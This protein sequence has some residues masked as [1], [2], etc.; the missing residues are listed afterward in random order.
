MPDTITEA[1]RKY[2]LDS[3]ADVAKWLLG[4]G[5]D[6]NVWVLEGNL[7]AGKTT[8]IKAICRE[9]GVNETMGSPTF[10][11]MNEY[12]D[13]KGRSVFHFD[14]YRLKNEAEAYDI[15]AEEYFDSDHLCLI[16]WADRIPTL[17][18]KKFFKIIIEDISPENRAIYFEKHGG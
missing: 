1:L 16:E 10:S 9:L 5:E 15:G 2:G 12:H 6:F 7:G 11:I 3:I 18:P 8:L 17:L 14:F 4:E 13:G